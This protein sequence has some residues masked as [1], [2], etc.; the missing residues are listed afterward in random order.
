MRKKIKLSLQ[1]LEKELELVKS[2]NHI[3]GGNGG[4][5]EIKLDDNGR[6]YYVD[7]T[8]RVHYLMDTQLLFEGI[9]DSGKSFAS[10]ASVGW[11]VMRGKFNLPTALATVGLTS[12]EKVYNEWVSKYFGKDGYVKVGDTSDEKDTSSGEDTT[13]P[14]EG[15]PPK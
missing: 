6:T 7:N 10:W 8:G 5:A 3:L 14:G 1:S 12:M 11:D 2:P 9:V 13:Y 15:L 4:G